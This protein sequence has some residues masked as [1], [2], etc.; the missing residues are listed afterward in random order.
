MTAIQ[1]L[2]FLWYR[3]LFYFTR[4]C[5]AR[6]TPSTR[7]TIRFEYFRDMMHQQY[8]G[9]P[10]KQ[11]SAWARWMKRPSNVIAWFRQQLDVFRDRR[12]ARVVMAM[13]VR[14][15]TRMHCEAVRREVVRTCAS[16]R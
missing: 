10:P 12:A 5:A 1:S 15:W 14:Y 2:T 8:G 9:T 13:P 16:A 6:T 3:M 4:F 11:P 7:P